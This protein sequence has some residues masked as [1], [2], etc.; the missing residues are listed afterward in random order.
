MLFRSGGQVVVGSAQLQHSANLLVVQQNTPRLGLDWQSFNI[1]SGA[2]VEFKQPNAS[3]VALNRVLGNSGTEIYG[4]LKANGQVFL[5]NPN[6]VL[7]A[8]GAKVDVGGLVAST[9]DLSQQDFAAGRYVFNAVEKTGSVVNQGTIKANAGGYLALFGQQVDNQGAISV[10]AGSVLLASGRAATV[11]ISG[12]GLIS[13]VVTPGAQGRI[14]N[15]GSL[16]ADGGTVTLTAQSAQ[17]IAASLVNNSGL[18]RANTLVERSGEIWI[19]GDQVASSGKITADAVGSGKAGRVSLL[20]DMA[21]GSVAVGGEISARS[22]SGA[23]GQVETSAAL[24]S[25]ARST[26]VDTRGGEGVGGNHGTWTIDPTDF[27]VSSGGA[28]QTASGIGA[29]TLSAKIGRAHV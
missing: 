20:G 7:F 25:V 15:S 4:Q 22:D 23:G 12:S 11:S 19:T 16:S 21:H 9:L 26:R 17:D 13:A 8:P 3:S 10:D 27:T 2:T 1:G 6:G 18:I 5:T 28:A 24:V 14:S 29:D